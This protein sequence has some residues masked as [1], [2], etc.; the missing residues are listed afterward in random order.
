MSTDIRVLQVEDSP[1]DAELM[2]R[3]LKKAGFLVYSERIE[4][5]AEMRQLLARQQWDVIVADYRLPNFDAPAAL[6]VL[7]E[8]GKD[9]PFIV[10]SGAIGEDVA[11]EMMRSGAHDYLLKDRLER[12]APAVER[13]IRAARIRRQ[14][15]QAQEDRS[16]AHSELAAIS[17]NAPVMLLVVNTDLHVEK[18]NNMA[19]R[20]SG[21]P[22]HE[23]IGAPLGEVIGCGDHDPAACGSTQH[24]AECVI[25]KS[26]TTA[27]Q[28]AV[29]FESI[30]LWRPVTAGEQRQD[31]CFMVSI[32]PLALGTTRKALICAQDV[33]AHKQAEQTLRE[34]V[35]RLEMAVLEKA[36]LFQ[37]VHHRVK[38]NLQI[39]ASLLSMQARSMPDEDSAGKLKDTEQ[40]VKAMAMVHEQLYGQ[41]EISSVDLA[42]YIR[43]LAPQLVSSHPKGTSITLRLDLAQTSLSLERSIPC[44]LILTELITNALKYAY[45]EG[46]GEIVVR[47]LS[48]SSTVEL[49]VSDSGVGLPEGLDLKNSQTLGMNIVQALAKQIGGSLEIG[50]GP[51]CVFTVRIPRESENRPTAQQAGQTSSTEQER[52]QSQVAVW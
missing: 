3:L 48:D 39:I 27:I 16:A 44:G 26:V 23:L 21:R 2:L 18:L 29:S 8:T 49:T 35:D 34:T 46:S 20:L 40:R 45:P 32:A 42:A 1:D 51:G 17:S 24:C 50:A 13:E 12:L 28:S 19:A 11:V 10:V 5:A 4:T 37:E 9:I 47:L 52:K 41:K 30:E 22:L 25:H 33:T 15:R 36:V 7:Q 14:H 31:R 43:T 38:N 6:S